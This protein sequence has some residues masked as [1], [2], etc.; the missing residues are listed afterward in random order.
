MVLG[1]HLE[2]GFRV[3]ALSNFV[4]FGTCRKEMV[5]NDDILRLIT[6]RQRFPIHHQVLGLSMALT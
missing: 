3:S 6:N 4:E 2:E 1:M 5:E